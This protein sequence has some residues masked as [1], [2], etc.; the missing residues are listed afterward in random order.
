MRGIYVTFTSLA[1]VRLAAPQDPNQ[2]Y[3]LRQASPEA[4]RSGFVQPSGL[5]GTTPSQSVSSCHPSP[6]AERTLVM[7]HPGDQRQGR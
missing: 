4:E 7:T 6:G 1:F 2:A 3:L 5:P